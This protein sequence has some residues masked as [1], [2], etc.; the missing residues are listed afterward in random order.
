MILWGSVLII[1]MAAERPFF[2]DFIFDVL[3]FEKYFSEFC[4]ILKKFVGLRSPPEY[5][6]TVIL[7]DLLTLS[8]SSEA[9]E[10]KGQVGRLHIH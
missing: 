1:Y 10:L 5:G 7:I 2:S 3:I 9:I 4:P 8:S 6:S